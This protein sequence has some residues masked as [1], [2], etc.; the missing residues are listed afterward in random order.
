VFV[1][2]SAA[3]DVLFARTTKAGALPDGVADNPLPSATVGSDT[4]LETDRE[5]KKE[6][7]PPRRPRSAASA[8][9][10]WQHDDP[11]APFCAHTSDGREL[12]YEDAERWQKRELGRMV[13][14]AEYGDLNVPANLREPD[15]DR[16]DLD[17]EVA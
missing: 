13:A 14:F 4:P 6:R 11:D 1:I 9:A 10:S 7:K 3:R 12:T 16:E 2:S 8:E 15:S 17:K 5:N